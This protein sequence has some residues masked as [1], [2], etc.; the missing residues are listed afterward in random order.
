MKVTG[1]VVREV[2]LGEADKLLTLICNDVGRI[3]VSA[4]GV[5]SL[6]SPHV[7]TTQPFCYSS[8]VLKRGRKFYYISESELVEPFFG[9]RSDL[10]RVSLASYFCDILCELSPE[11]LVDESMLRLTLNSFYAMSEKKEI[12][13]RLIKAAYEFKAACISGYAPDLTSCTRCGRSEH[14][15]LYL[16]VMNGGLV[17]GDCKTA[18]VLENEMN[19]TGTA[20]IHLPLTKT[21]RET[22]EFLESSDE[23]H[24]LSFGIDDTELKNLAKICER[25]LSEHL[26]H[27]FKSLEFYKS[28]IL[29]N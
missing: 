4:K 22:L 16:D 5:R 20:M 12:P 1:L 3:D 25:Y 7:T 28:L 11:G 14:A 27:G 29:D 6:K 23:K 17:C 9:L 15:K 26:E 18:V 10:D 21:V 19:Q 2:R 13:L 8:F 24:F